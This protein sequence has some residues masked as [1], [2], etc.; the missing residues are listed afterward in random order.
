MRER[1]TAV[2]CVYINRLLPMTKMKIAI[3]ANE[4][5]V[6]GNRGVKTYSREIINGLIRL[7]KENEY[8]ICAS[9]DISG[10]L[11]DAGSN[12][13]ILTRN[14]HQRFWAFRTFAKMVEEIAPDVVFLPIQIYPFFRQA[15]IK[16]KVVVMIHDLAFLKY[17][18]NFT[19]ARRLLLE[20]HTRRA[21][22]LSDRIIV[23]SQ[24]TKRDI[25]NTYGVEEGKVAVVSHGISEKYARNEDGKGFA[26]NLLGGSPYLLFVGT[27]QPRKNIEKLVEGFE[28]IKKN[29]ENRDLM[30]VICGGKGWQCE[31]ILK[32]IE[33]SADRG[34]IIMTGAVDDGELADLYQNACVFIMPSLYEGFGLPV[35][36]AMSCGVPV[37]AAD[38]SSLGEIVGANGVMFNALIATDMAEKVVNVLADKELR[39]ELSQKALRRAGEFSWGRSSKETLDVFVKAVK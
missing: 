23:P 10:E 16:P 26:R 7:D 18:E 25:I 24:S 4:L 27:I 12:V 19:L 15:A 33:D 36:E 3:Y 1:S 21:A 5:T 34:D 35:L 39:T 28:I 13:S 14:P 11:P 2:L 22:V 38:N 31:E 30:L 32:R 20:F 17:P 29:A 8:V 37:L 9:R 6:A